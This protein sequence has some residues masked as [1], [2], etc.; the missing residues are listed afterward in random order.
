ML[1]KRVG[2][3]NNTVVL[4]PVDKLGIVGGSPRLRAFDGLSD[5]PSM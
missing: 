3:G 2:M 4:S 5:L 1:M